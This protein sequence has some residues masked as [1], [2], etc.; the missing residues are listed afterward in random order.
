[1]KPNTRSDEEIAELLNACDK[2]AEAGGSKF[3]GMTYEDG[4]RAAIDWLLGDSDENPM[5]D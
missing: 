3:R 4:V 1:M 2:Q 5:A